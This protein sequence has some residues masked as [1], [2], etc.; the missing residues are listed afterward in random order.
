MTGTLTGKIT[1][2]TVNPW[3]KNRSAPPSWVDSDPY[4]GLDANSRV[5]CQSI[6][7]GAPGE[8]VAPTIG[9]GEYMYVNL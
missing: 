3:K 5:A 1:G 6:A 2:R 7:T 4:A 9:I 8:P